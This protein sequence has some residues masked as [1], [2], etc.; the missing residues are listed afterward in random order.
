MSEQRPRQ[1]PRILHL[2]PV[3]G[4]GG[5]EV[6]AKS[7]RARQDLPCRFRLQFIEPEPPQGRSAGSIGRMLAAN[8]RALR[9]ARDFEPEVILCSLWRSVPLALALRAIHRRAKLVFF[10]HLDTTTHRLDTLL[11]AAAIRVAD[12]IWG[13]SVATLAARDIAT[14]R[15]RV[16]SFVTERAPLLD[17]RFVGAR[18]VS[19]GR[20]N[21]Q[22][23]YDRALHLIGLLAR[24]GIDVRYSIYGPDG[25]ER[26]TLIA[27][28]TT[29][30]LADRVRFPGPVGRDALAEIAAQHS[31]FLQPSR[32]E[33]MC[34]AA[35][36]AMQLGLVPAATAVGQM[37][38]YVIPDENGILI[39][40]DR[41]DRAADKLA[42]L[43]EEPKRWRD[44][45]Q[46]AMRYWQNAALYADDVCHAATDLAS[47]AP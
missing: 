12:E 36:E 3:D 47:R 11:S 20:L 37:A 4:I 24:R 25:G 33:G 34:M 14:D 2:V 1:G 42:A 31:F 30:G 6:A 10:I 32:S 40:P 26:D 23:G 17:K 5:V 28:A 15:S 7:M 18:F 21:H 44:H 22:K 8:W 9:A 46:A 38:H 41:L 13:D 27:L 39:D 29:L 19:W 45:S 43:I 35:V 16:I